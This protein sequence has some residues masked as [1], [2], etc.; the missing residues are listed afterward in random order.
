MNLKCIVFVLLATFTIH[1][2]FVINSINKD[3]TLCE[4]LYKMSLDDQKFR[5]A[6]GSITNSFN[7]VLDSLILKNGLTKE[8]YLLLP[9]TEQFP[10][11]KQAFE[12]ARRL[13]RSPMQQNDS[14]RILQNELDA[15][16]TRTLIKITK[17]HGWLTAQK[18]SCNQKFKT[19]L[20][21]RH[22]PKKYWKEIRELIELERKEKRMSG[23][24]HYV[25]DNHLK[26]RPPMTKKPSDFID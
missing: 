1:G 15:I 10:L 3:E 21:F 22:A 6:K 25:I 4:I 26:G 8:S 14:L 20:I 12:V 23:Y 11:K 18:L 5:G 16:N 9:D 24:E 2:V 19:V 7:S 17:E 13:Q